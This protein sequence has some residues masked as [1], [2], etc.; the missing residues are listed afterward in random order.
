MNLLD[1]NS[2]KPIVYVFAGNMREVEFYR[3]KEGLSRS[4]VLFVTDPHMLQGICQPDD[5]IIAVL[6]GSFWTRKDAEIIY[7]YAVSRGFEPKPV[8]I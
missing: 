6:V 2:K 1:V 5:S 3:Y 8:A 4:Q 7:H